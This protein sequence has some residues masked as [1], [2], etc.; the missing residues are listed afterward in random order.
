MTTVSGEC[1]AHRLSVA[2]HSSKHSARGVGQERA[3]ATLLV[4]ALVSTDSAR[5][6]PHHDQLWLRFIYKLV[7]LYN[8]YIIHFQW[9]Y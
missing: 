6:A 3:G 9:P 5:V 8:K 4:R 2:S 1:S 7:P